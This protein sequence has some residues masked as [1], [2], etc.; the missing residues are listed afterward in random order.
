M[1]IHS[2]FRD[3]AKLDEDLIFPDLKQY[4]LAG[5]PKRDDPIYVDQCW[6]R[7]NQIIS[8]FKN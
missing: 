4:L 1:A 2:L 6:H 7:V 5:D 3:I 8:I